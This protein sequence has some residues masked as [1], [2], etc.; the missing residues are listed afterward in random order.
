MTVSTRRIPL[1]IIPLLLLL[2]V[3][4]VSFLWSLNPSGPGDQTEFAI[5]LA[6]ILVSMAMVSYVFRLEK[7]GRSADRVTLL[8]GCL[9]LLVLLLSGLFIFS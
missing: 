6:V 8:A 9:V 5:S 4:S 7:W 3:T 1:R 2:Q